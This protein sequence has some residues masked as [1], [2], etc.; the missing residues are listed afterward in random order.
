MC[1]R[2]ARG[3]DAL[4]ASAGGDALDGGTGSDTVDY[5]ARPPGAT[6]NLT[7]GVGASSGDADLLS[8]LENA[9]GSAGADLL[10]GDGAVNTLSGGN[11]NDTLRGLA[12]AD[13]LVGGG[14]VDTVDYSTFFPANGRI[15]VVVNLTAGEALGDGVDSLAGIQNVKGSSFDDRLLG[16]AQAN[17]LQGADGRD[18]IVGAAGKDFL[19]G[20][21]GTDTLQARDGTR[22]RVY[23]G[24]DRDRARVDRG[25]DS[26]RSIA[27]FLP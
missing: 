14:G 24:A 8:T 5:S 13:S 18:F 19:Q 6:V 20:G 11:G 3:N 9:V 1:S 23:G 26:V 27:V 17:T 10:V 4:V 7:T 15:G 25:R 12:G 16:N 21:N 2:A 22:D